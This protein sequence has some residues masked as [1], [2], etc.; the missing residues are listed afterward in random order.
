MGR[1]NF[2][3]LAINLIRENFMSNNALEKAAFHWAAKDEVEAQEYKG[4]K[5]TDFGYDTRTAWIQ[6]AFEKIQHNL[7]LRERAKEDYRVHRELEKTPEAIVANVAG[8]GG[9]GL[10]E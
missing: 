1:V 6:G 3:F 8:S 4:A 10:G 5:P 9:R 7:A 2:C